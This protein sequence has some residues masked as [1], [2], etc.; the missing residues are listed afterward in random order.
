MV[1]KGAVY[2]TYYDIHFVLWNHG[3]LLLVALLAPL[4]GWSLPPTGPWCSLDTPQECPNTSPDIVYKKSV[5]EQGCRGSSMVICGWTPL[6]LPLCHSVH[7]CHS[8]WDHPLTIHRWTP[9]CIP[10]CHSVHGWSMDGMAMVEWALIHPK[11]NHG[12]RVVHV[13]V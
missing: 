1:T 11:R 5:Y 2:C 12:E 6:S 10:L 8:S 13:C 3:T 7:G 4:S 9:L